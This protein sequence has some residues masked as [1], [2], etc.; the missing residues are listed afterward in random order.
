MGRGLCS[1]C[2]KRDRYG[3]R[4]LPE[5]P[6]ACQSCGRGWDTVK[7]TAAGLCSGC[8]GTHRYRKNRELVRQP[9]PE[10]CTSC[11]RTLRHKRDPA[12]LGTVGYA[13]KGLCGACTNALRNGKTRGERRPHRPM[14]ER[15]TSC[16]RK[17]RKIG[18]PKVPDTVVF[19]ANGMCGS[20]YNAARTGATVTP[21]TTPTECATCQRPMRTKGNAA[22]GFVTHRARGMCN[23]CYVS[24]A[25][26][27]RQLLAYVLGNAS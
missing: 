3:Y 2:W 1:Q 16:S 6:P 7:Y 15:C 12:T 13:G 26:R 19:V 25:E 22:P 20:C 11:S 17:L 14:P 5:R 18:T 23:T 27:E 9:M 4:P 24:E 21:R 10:R 8:Y